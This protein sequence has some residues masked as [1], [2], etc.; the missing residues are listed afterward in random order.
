MNFDHRA[1]LVGDVVSNWVSAVGGAGDAGDG[2]RHQRW[3]F[4]GWRSH[5]EISNQVDVET[6][7]FPQS[8]VGDD[9]Y[10]Q[11]VPFLGDALARV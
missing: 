5:D 8:E 1:H 9:G 11:R 7:K 10:P 4:L 3:D 2:N 6:G